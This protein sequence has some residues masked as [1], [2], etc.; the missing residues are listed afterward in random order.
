MNGFSER[1][2]KAMNT[3]CSSEFCTRDKTTDETTEMREGTGVIANV[4]WGVWQWLLDTVLHDEKMR[5]DRQRAALVPS[6][7]V[8]DDGAHDHPAWFD[9]HALAT[10][11]QR[12]FD[13]RRRYLQLK[14]RRHIRFPLDLF[15]R[16]QSRWH[17]KTKFQ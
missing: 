17:K 16:I 4:L 14:R 2:S 7:D 11:G 8:N 13:V 9:E 3:S 5:F 15:L 10:R 1:L 12:S 6:R